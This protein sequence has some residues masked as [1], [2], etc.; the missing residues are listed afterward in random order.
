M[1]QESFSDQIRRAIDSS[2]YSRYAICK[3]IKVDQSTMSRFMN[4]GGG[5]SMDGLDRLA[6]LLGLRITTGNKAGGD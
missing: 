6:E 5:M 1:G 4:G 3:R 2:G